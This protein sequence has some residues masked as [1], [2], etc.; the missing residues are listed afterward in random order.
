MMSAPAWI[1]CLAFHCGR[2][3]IKHL[4]ELHWPVNQVDLMGILEHASDYRDCPVQC[5]HAQSLVLAPQTPPNKLLS[6]SLEVP[7]SQVFDQ[8]SW[9]RKLRETLDDPTTVFNSDFPD[10]D[11]ILCTIEHRLIA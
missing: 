1:T 11:T 9:R 6:E 5:M 4:A 2:G 10:K 3:P 7:R 8:P